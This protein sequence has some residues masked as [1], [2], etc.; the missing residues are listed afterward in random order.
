LRRITVSGMYSVFLLGA[1]VS[2][3][4]NYEYAEEFHMQ[5]VSPDP[6]KGIYNVVS[7]KKYSDSAE[8]PL[9]DSALWKKLIIEYPGI[10]H[11]IAGAE[12]EA[13][14]FNRDSIN[15]T[16]IRM[17]NFA[18]STVSYYFHYAVNKDVLTMNGKINTDSLSITL[19]RKDIKKSELLSREF[20]WV[21]EYP[22]NR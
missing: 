11:V 21:N 17:N 12:M 3:Y 2:F 4:D 7:F 6:L 5:T 20:H 15:K 19:K 22:Y 13:Y 16:I 18:D 10:A 9:N 8:V 1:T 14:A